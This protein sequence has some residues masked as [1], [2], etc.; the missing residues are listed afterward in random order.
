MLPGI[1]FCAL[2][3]GHGPEGEDFEGD[4]R[5]IVFMFALK[6]FEQFLKMQNEKGRIVVS[7]GVDPR[8]MIYGT[9]RTSCS[10]ISTRFTRL[11]IY[12]LVKYIFSAGSDRPE[13]DFWPV[14]KSICGLTI[15]FGISSRS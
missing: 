2:S 7:R 13:S 3:S 1:F 9:W 5:E 15:N 11:Q 6:V 12:N 8:Q 10:F 14:Q 4:W